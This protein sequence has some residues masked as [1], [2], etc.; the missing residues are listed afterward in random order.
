MNGPAR[1]AGSRRMAKEQAGGW[2]EWFTLGVYK[3]SQGRI[4]RQATFCAL[5]L[6]LVLGVWSLDNTLSDTLPLSGKYAVC[7]A[8][9]VIGTWLAYRAMNVPRFADF[10]IAVE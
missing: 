4:A 9:L 5:V 7:G 2:G 1:G 10:L 3:R 8:V 6:A